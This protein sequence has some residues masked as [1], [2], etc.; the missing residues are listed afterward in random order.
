MT[1][2]E[3]DRPVPPKHKSGGL[4]ERCGEPHPVAG[5]RGTKERMPVVRAG[6]RTEGRNDPGR[7]QQRGSDS[8]RTPK[9]RGLWLGRLCTEWG[10]V[11][12]SGPPDTGSERA[13]V[14]GDGVSTGPVRDEQAKPGLQSGL[15]P[16][17]LHL[18]PGPWGAAALVS[19]GPA[20]VPSPVQRGPPEGAGP[21]PGR[22]I[23]VGPRETAEIGDP[24]KA[25]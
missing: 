3:D 21:R 24:S 11:S 16:P 15:T 4:L 25:Q 14:S 20:W 2:G 19:R 1:G 6:A 7:G 10:D 23:K 18:R 8:S 17:F 12:L 5:V 13:T 22:Y 9:H